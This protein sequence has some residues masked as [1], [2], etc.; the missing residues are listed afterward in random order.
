MSTYCFIK[1]KL[2]G[3][4]ID[5]QGAS[6]KSGA[7]LDAFPQKK[8]ANDN[9]LWEFVPDPAGSGYFFIK[10]KLDGNVIDIQGAST[11]SG[12]A[13]DSFPMKST[14]NDN[15]LW[16][17]LQDPAGS[18]Y[19]F[20]KSKMDG[21]VI[22]I[23]QASTKSGA[24]LDAFPM[25]STENDNQLW[26]AVDGT[27][28]SPVQ[29]SNNLTWSNLGTG[30]E[31]NTASSGANECNYALSLTIQQ[32]GTWHFFGSYANRGTVPVF[33]APPQTF[34]VSIVVHDLSGKGYSFSQ[35]GFIPSA[36]QA[37]S[38]FNWNVNQKAPA[39]AANW[40]SIA[41]RNQATYGFSNNADLTL[42][43]IL[44]QIAGAIESAVSTTET[45]VADVATVVSL[46][47]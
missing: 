2:D 21:H 38:D 9:Q 35:G 24:G 26:M 47:A 25:K 46:V 27:F 12:V 17:F 36:P 19:C 34:G 23:E 4:V 13:L 39:I 29:L 44:G 45:V 32:D 33:T 16:Q 1:S 11:K 43:D 7:L 28:P 42:G 30:P 8:T 22:D 10:N 37:G 6:A 20:I 14:G 3:N 5:I 41:A 15:Q 40:D 31:P 18:G